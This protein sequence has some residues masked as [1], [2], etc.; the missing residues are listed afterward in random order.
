MIFSP[1][2]LY[3]EVITGAFI[4]DNSN[5][6]E[7]T[8]EWV[9]IGKCRCDDNDAKEKVFVEK[10]SVNGIIHDYDFHIVY[11]GE[12]LPVG[13]KVRAL[14]KDGSVRGEGEVI[15]SRKYNYFTPS[16]EIWI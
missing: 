8:A 15:K 7:G 1:H 4:D 12:K 14:N 3:K 5:P 11:E 13:T 6:H 16:A 9:T 2:I 10:V